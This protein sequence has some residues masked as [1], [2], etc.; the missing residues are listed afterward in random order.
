[1]ILKASHNIFFYKFFSVYA[2]LKIK[3]AFRKVVISGEVTDKGKPVLVISNH[4]SWW[5]GFWIMYMNRKLFGRKF[6]F[7]MQEEHLRKHMFFNKTGGYSVRKGS[8]TVLE[9]IAYTIELLK[10]KDNLV[11]IFPQGEIRT[12][13]QH[14]IH[15]EKGI[16]R[17]LNATGKDIQI[18]FAVNLIDYFSESKASLFV[19]LKDHEYVNGEG[20][21]K[22]Y[23]DFYLLT[24]DKH[25]ELKN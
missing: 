4:F 3:S 1:M 25:R 8:R 21:E 11:L 6:F 23:N 20:I 2:M 17:I 18:V 5:D 15:F 14:D 13:Y 9:T 16:C 24:L 22:S 12:L 7:M 19:Y 10:Q